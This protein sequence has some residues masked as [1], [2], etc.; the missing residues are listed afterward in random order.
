VNGV[1]LTGTG[2]FGYT[3]AEWLWSVCPQ[4]LTLKAGE[5]ELAMSVMYGS[6]NLDALALIPVK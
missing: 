4:V 1:E 3:P 5:H 6:A 2:G